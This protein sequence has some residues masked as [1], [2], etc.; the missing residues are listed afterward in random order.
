MCD[1]GAIEKGVGHVHAAF[2][3]A[4]P[5]GISEGM[6]IFNEEMLRRSRNRVRSRDLWGIGQPFS[7]LPTQAVEAK[8]ATGF[9]GGF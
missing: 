7:A 4:Q 9:A 1:D 6:A 3:E 5:E 2:T 8:C